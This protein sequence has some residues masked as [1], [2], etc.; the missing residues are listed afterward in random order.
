MKRS[1]ERSWERRER[2]RRTLRFFNV[3]CDPRPFY[4]HLLLY[5][6]PTF[7]AE[8]V[9]RSGGFPPTFALT[10]ERLPYGACVDFFNADIKLLK[11]APKCS[12][13]FS[14]SPMPP[15]LRP[16]VPPSSLPPESRGIVRAGYFTSWFSD[17]SMTFIIGGNF[18]YIEGEIH[19]HPVFMPLKLSLQL[20]LD[21]LLI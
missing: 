16:S 2:R 13:V 12:F 18:T 4:F 20:L 21:T 6:Y 11:S 5:E 14:L 10:Q 7:R 15:S 1:G 3:H 19:N 17:G 8:A 9:A